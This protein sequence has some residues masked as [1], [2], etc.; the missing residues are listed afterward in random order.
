VLVERNNHG[1]AVLL[2]LEDN[3]RLWRLEG[4]DGN[5]GWLT[6]KGKALLYDA[7]ADAFRE[8]E[9]LLHSF[10]TFTQL[11]SIEGATLR[12]RRASTTTGPTPTRWRWRGSA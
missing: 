7:A 10:A 4:H 6:T 3:S 1:H 11:A 5:E 9:T 2:W 12:A 8:G